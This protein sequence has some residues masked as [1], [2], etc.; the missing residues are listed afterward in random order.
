MENVSRDFLGTSYRKANFYLGEDDDINV[1]IPKK[2]VK[3][4]ITINNEN[5]MISL[6]EKSFLDKTDKYSYF[7]G[8][9]HSIVE[10]ETGVKND[11]K[12]LVIKDSFANSFIPFLVNH[13]ESI[14]LIDPRYY[15]GSIVDYMG[16]EKIDE[17]LF[18]FNIQTFVQEKKFYVLSL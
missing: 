5:K 6:Y 18:L 14:I 8:G 7:L 13:Y 4:D 9:D 1:Y 12:I 17:V 10:I 15:N 11:K 16:D 3:Y 2:E